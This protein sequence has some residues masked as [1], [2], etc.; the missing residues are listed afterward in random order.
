MIELRPNHASERIQTLATRTCK[1]HL[2]YQDGAWWAFRPW[3][4][5]IP[6]LEKAVA[7]VTIN[8]SNDRRGKH[9]N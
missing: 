3:S 4:A 6:F 9:G 2:Y 8:N 5:T 7:W 1:I